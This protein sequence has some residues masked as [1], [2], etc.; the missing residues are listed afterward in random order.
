MVILISW[1]ENH[2]L[3][4]PCRIQKYSRNTLEDFRFLTV[5]IMSLKN[6]IQSKC[7]AYVQLWLLMKYGI[8][9]QSGYT[10]RD[11]STDMKSTVNKFTHGEYF[12]DKIK[13]IALCYTPLPI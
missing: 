8:A 7:N 5:E 1:Q 6:P 9:T 3:Q 4:D 2:N 11:F 12:F 13:F 10:A